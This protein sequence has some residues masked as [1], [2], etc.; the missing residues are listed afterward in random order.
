MKLA[1]WIAQHERTPR[2]R[3]RLGSP[4]RWVRTVDLIV[5]VLAPRLLA[6]KFPTLALRLL[7][8]SPR[9][10]TAQVLPVYATVKM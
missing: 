9:W 5:H 3:F 1:E 7:R 10:G 8:T 6:S 2:S 4:C